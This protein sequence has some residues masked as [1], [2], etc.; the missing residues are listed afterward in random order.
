MFRFIKAFKTDTETWHFRV[1]R[2]KTGNPQNLVYTLSEDWNSFFRNLEDLNKAGYGIYFTVNSGG[3]KKIDISKFNAFFIDIDDERSREAVQEKIDALGI[4][5]SI[6]VMSSENKYHLYWSINEEERDLIATEEWEGVQANLIAHFNSDT[7]VKDASR[8]LRVPYFENTKYDS[9]PL[10]QVERFCPN[11][12][13]GIAEI[14]KRLSQLNTDLDENRPA[15]NVESEFVSPE[16]KEV[17]TDMA[18]ENSNTERLSGVNP[19]SR[20]IIREGDRDTYFFD[21]ACKLIMGG[22]T[23]EEAFAIL[24][25]N[26][27]RCETVTHEFTEAELRVKCNQAMKYKVERDRVAPSV[28]SNSFLAPSQT[29]EFTKEQIAKALTSGGPLPHW[30]PESPPIVL[31]TGRGD[32]SMIVAKV[33]GGK[34]MFLSNI[35]MATACGKSFLNIVE[36][37]T[38]RKVVYLDYESNTWLFTTRIKRMKDKYI[39]D[40]LEL[41]NSNFQTLCAK[42]ESFS[43]NLSSERSRETFMNA[44]IESKNCP[45]LLIFDTVTQAFTLKDENSNAEVKEKVIKPLQE[46]AKK[47]NCAVLFAHHTDKDGKAFRGASTLADGPLV[48]MIE[49]NQTKG[50]LGTHKLNFI[51]VKSSGVL[52][53]TAKYLNFTDVFFEFESV[54]ETSGAQ[55]VKDQILAFINESKGKVSTSSVLQAIP[56]SR[57]TI[58]KNLTKLVR[59][60]K[61]QK[62]GQGVYK[63]ITMTRDEFDF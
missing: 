56:A 4:E 45:D 2:P 30:K 33:N 43:L 10:V 36:A 13:L 3:T 62:L 11:E 20:H 34:T 32:V 16:L 29:I 24:K 23:A 53:S 15:N 26:L 19:D 39:G 58:S 8:I 6:I 44:L 52:D 7:V 42:Q 28:S 5:P 57:Q 9:R 49:K 18:A 37:G 17:K 63:S 12:Q 61:I 21:S 38:P 40:E 48:L 51:K 59:E 54:T 41:I 46:M 60:K 35:A 55:S 22:C 25:P 50:K 31:S 14:K 27:V 1:I 47:M